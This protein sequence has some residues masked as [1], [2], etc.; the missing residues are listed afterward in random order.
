M[1]L[2]KFK[3]GKRIVTVVPLH[4]ELAIG[5]LKGVLELA[6]VDLEEFLKFV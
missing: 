3:E 1:V 4:D 2:V 5:T 6:K